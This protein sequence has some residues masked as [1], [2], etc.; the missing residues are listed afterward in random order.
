MQEVSFLEVLQV[1]VS[2]VTFLSLFCRVVG[3]Q[4]GTEMLFSFILVVK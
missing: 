3:K 2:K 4:I 1:F